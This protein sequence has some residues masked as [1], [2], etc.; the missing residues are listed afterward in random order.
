MIATV[1]FAQASRIGDETLAIREARTV[2]VAATSFSANEGSVEHLRGRAKKAVGPTAR[3]CKRRVL[4]RR[5]KTRSFGSHY[6]GRANILQTALQRAR[7]PLE[8][9]SPRGKQILN[10]ASIAPRHA[11]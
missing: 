8:N 2:L 3:A 10:F 5:Y 4:K 9:A 7:G 6:G 11:A 1:S